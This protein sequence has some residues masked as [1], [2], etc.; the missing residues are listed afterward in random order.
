M[1]TDLTD[2]YVAWDSASGTEANKASAVNSSGTDIPSDWDWSAVNKG[3]RISI[4]ARAFGNGKIL[5]TTSVG[6]V[7]K[8]AYSEVIVRGEIRVSNVGDETANVSLNLNNFLSIM[9]P[10]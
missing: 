6:G 2:N 7:D 5:E 8:Y 3:A 9:D 1:P 4:R 10:S